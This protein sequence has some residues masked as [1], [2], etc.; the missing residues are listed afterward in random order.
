MGDL[1]IMSTCTVLTPYAHIA[2][3]F[4]NSTWQRLSQ[5]AM[6]TCR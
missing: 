4:K 3:A 1:P 5:R 2:T 6:P